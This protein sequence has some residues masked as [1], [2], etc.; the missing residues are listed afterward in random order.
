MQ[1]LLALKLLLKA[2]RF[3]HL[4]MLGSR[5][6]RNIGQCLRLPHRA[7]SLLDLLLEVSQLSDSRVEV[8]CH[9]LALL[10]W[11]HAASDA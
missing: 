10:A 6:R 8:A 2:T 11:Q 7:L 5:Q 3:L 4:Q 1:S 9:A